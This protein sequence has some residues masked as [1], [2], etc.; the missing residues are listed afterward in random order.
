MPASRLTPEERWRILHLHKI[1]GMTISD[2][3]RNINRDYKTVKRWIDN[4]EETGKMDDLPRKGAP[5]KTSPKDDAYMKARA[6]RDD[7]EASDIKRGLKHKGG[8]EISERT[9]ARRLREGGLRYKSTKK[10]PPLKPEHFKER[11]RIAQQFKGRRWDRVLFTDYAKYELGSRK[12]YA[13]TKVG[14]RKYREKKSHP[15]S[16]NFWISFGRGG[17]GILHTFDE[18]LTGEMH[19]NI[20]RVYAPQAA[21]RLFPGRWWL[22]TDNDPK[23]VTFSIL[24]KLKALKINRL[25][26]SRYSPDLNTSENVIKILKD[27]TAKRNPT[28]IK[29]AKKYLQEEWKKI[30][31]SITSGL[32][33][34]MVNRCQAVIDAKGGHTD[35]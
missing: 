33:D 5:R 29:E 30:S 4:Y 23:I 10:K 28:S 26:F 6:N 25:P 14:E 17:P 15:P 24:Q 18:N 1:N 32:V 12:R 34:S 13:W 20:I 19:Y 31:P 11:V 21:K 9:I 3:S 35:Y 22:L 27:N 8:P 7:W 2:I 16:F